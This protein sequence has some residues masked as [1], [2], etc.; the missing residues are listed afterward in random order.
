VSRNWD[1]GKTLKIVLNCPVPFML[2]HG[3]AQI[4]IQRTKAALE[5]IGVETEYLRWWDET[6]T[7]DLLH[8]VA[9]LPEF[10]LDLARGKGWKVVNT[11]LFTETCNRS[12]RSLLL[13]KMCIRGMATLP[14]P[15]ALR[16]SLHWRTFP[17]VDQ[18]IIGLQAE[19]DLLQDV[20]GVA[21]EK[22]SVVPLGLTETFLKAG[23]AVR[24]EEHL[25]CTGRI[26][27]SKNSLE[28]AGLACAAK[29]PILFVGKP[30]NPNSPYWLE[31]RALID[32]KYVKHRDYVSSEAAIADLLRKARGYVL[33]SEYENWCLAAHEAAACGLPLLLP[34]Q[35]WSRERFGNQATYWP[36]TRNDTAALA[37]LQSF[38]EQCPKLPPPKVELYSW[39][40][41]AER[42]KDVYSR[43]LS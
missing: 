25:I 13:R 10:L 12:R 33:M 2:A 17:M 26:T 4:Q 42:L 34:D 14:L 31:F 39:I 3:G 32:G 38:S 20:Y 5:Q 37:A 19:R 28:L 9:T 30:G 1:K 6:Q 18:M 8:Q 41:V 22:I 27:E 43:M 40:E 29:V 36:R 21:P 23:P 7:A 11:V 16:S 35:R 15:I 24:T